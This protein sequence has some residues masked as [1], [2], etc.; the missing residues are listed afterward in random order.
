M[1]SATKSLRSGVDN[2]PI[3]RVQCIAM[4]T[5]FTRRIGR[6]LRKQT[7]QHNQH[8]NKYTSDRSPSDSLPYVIP[9]SNWR[10]AGRS[11]ATKRGR[12]GAAAFRG[13]VPID[14]HGSACG[15]VRV[16]EARTLRT[17]AARRIALCMVP[18]K[19]KAE[20]MVWMRMKR[21]A[22]MIIIAMMKRRMSVCIGLVHVH[23]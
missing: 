4:H 8:A 15:S 7:T 1:H 16:S 9:S 14:A 6:R 12:C 3:A 22:M 13:S 21:M 5:L 18:G 11:L 10:I 23:L 2:F 19:K 20:A 17:V